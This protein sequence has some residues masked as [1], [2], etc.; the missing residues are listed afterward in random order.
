MREPRRFERVLV[1]NR[2][3]IARR[4][5]RTLREMGIES[6]GVYSDADAE[7]PHA[8]EA[9]LAV[10]IGAGPARDSYL[11]IE[12]I[13][14]AA[15]R[16][17]ADALHPGYGFLAESAELAERCEA[18]GVTFIG[19][20][21]EV[22][23][24]LGSKLEAKATVAEVGVPVLP[25][26][27]TR[28]LSPGEIEKRVLE[29]GLP[30]VVKASAGGGGR[31]L[32][33]VARPD[34]IPAAMAAA[35]REAQ[36]AFGDDTL[37]VER[38]LAAPRHVEVQILGDRHGQTIH[39]FERECSIQR[40]HQ[41]LIEEA[42]SPA[43]DAELRERLCEAALTAARAVGYVGAGTMEF[44]LD[45]D[46]RF[47]FLEANP[48]LQ[49]EHAVTEAVTGLDLVQLQI[50]IAAGAPLPLEQRDLRLSGHAIEAR[51]VAEDP[52]RDFRPSTGR[53][54]LWEAPRVG[55][56]RCDAGVDTG[57]QVTV[58]YDSLLAR[59][60]AH[61]ESREAARQRL[62]H[63]LRQ[64]GLAGV[65][66]NRAFLIQALEHPAFVSGDT[67]TDFIETHIPR[68]RRSPRLEPERLR[69][70]A[71]AA[72]LFLH[73][74][75]RARGGPLPE[76][77]PSG[78]RNNRFRGQRERYRSGDLELEISYVAEGDATFAIEAEGAGPDGSSRARVVACDPAGIRAE[79]DGVRQRF[80]VARDADRIF[81]LGPDGSS[82]LTRVP[83][84]PR[85]RRDEIAQGCVA[86]MTGVI[87]EIHVSP[88]DR[89]RKGAPLLVLE[90]M[91][92]D[93][94]LIARA[95]GVV[96]EIRVRVDQQV[97]P[98]E[99]LIVIE[100]EP[101]APSKPRSTPPSGS[102]SGTRGRA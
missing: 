32:R 84:F 96:R 22:L 71:I 9:D 82:E 70:H 56:V 28:G 6:V 4:I 42:P 16:T 45:R 72:T 48:R 36:L 50:Q 59:L 95:S 81:V 34:E 74:R 2:G 99:V 18:A 63:G 68:G 55:G 24:R 75:R 35:G 52:E 40:R 13:L 91:K 61:G 12:R 57:T 51:V 85:D 15:R 80:R 41:K 33:K 93:H 67:Q 89:V 27:A 8:N 62:A 54:A 100:S 69:R 10:R 20:S 83:R 86:P 79:L 31:G 19:P 92:M 46:G 60:I 101:T 47:F 49:V 17:R 44:L 23:R 26:F 53:V 64:L 11:S 97:D 65:A 77:I 73:E 94:E 38:L 102:R 78:W 3:E 30:V 14:E 76:G 21:P 43:L 5:F 39:C 98:D 88:G 25:G 58:H 29:V 90:A 37:L 66:N 7:A 1:A 87:R